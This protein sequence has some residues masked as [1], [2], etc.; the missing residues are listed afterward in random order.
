MWSHFASEEA[1][2]ECNDEEKKTTG[3][4]SKW[5]GEGSQSPGGGTLPGQS[6]CAPSG[7]DGHCGSSQGRSGLPSTS[8]ARSAR[9]G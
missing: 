7:S 9:I 6:V 3:K 8:L 2:K 4:R 5:N 1:S